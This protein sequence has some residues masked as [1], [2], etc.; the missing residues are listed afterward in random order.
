MISLSQTLELIRSISFAALALCFFLYLAFTY[1]PTLF[2]SS[3]TTREVL[4]IGSGIGTILHRSLHAAMFNPLTKS[5]A[6]SFAFYAK[7][8]ELDLNRRSG[9]INENEWRLFGGQLKA[10]YF[11]ISESPTFVERKPISVNALPPED[12]ESRKLE[13]QTNQSV[14]HNPTAG[15]S[16]RRKKSKKS[17][18]NLVDEATTRGEA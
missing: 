14:R 7:V 9:I 3:M 10:Q 6:R 11:G 17:A 2:P 12:W 5:V 15:Q 18:K 1:H 8:V 16:K 13:E 4:F